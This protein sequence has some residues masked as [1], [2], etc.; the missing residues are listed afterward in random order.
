MISIEQ[1]SSL[2]QVD[3]SQ[4]DQFAGRRVLASYGWLLTVRETQSRC[5]PTRYFLA[6][7]A[8]ELVG[9]VICEL[10][11]SSEGSDLRALLFGRLA[12][13]ATCLRLDTLPSLVCGARM[14]VLE[15]LLIRG[16]M[17]GERKRRIESI[18]A[19]LSCRKEHRQDDR[20]LGREG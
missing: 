6:R 14:G 15:P 17:T 4:W 2:S 18:T 7:T 9:A 13:A 1:V 5:N 8:A 16:D 3:A 20:S 10:H 19:A 11:E 12:K